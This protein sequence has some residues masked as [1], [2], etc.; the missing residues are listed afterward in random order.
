[1]H[2]RPRFAL[3]VSCEHASNARPPDFDTTGMEEAVFLTHAAWDPGAQPIAARIAQRFAAP[4]AYGLWTRLYCD[5]NR[6]P[7]TAEVVPNTA[8]GVEIPSNARLDPAA[9]E[10]RVALYHQAYWDTVRAAIDDGLTKA[11]AVLHF[12]VH[13]FVEEYQGR[14]RPVDLGILVDP[15]A[16]LEAELSQYFQAHLPGFLVRENEP[17]DGRADALT[18]ALRRQYAPE[19]YAGVELE[20]NQRHLGHLGRVGDAVEAALEGLLVLRR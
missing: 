12:S 4:A 11:D 20:I 2:P 15:A 13:S 8:F 7:G 14:F 9:R 5:L 19:R 18:T 1:M 16:P 6:S 17:Y 3:V 10:R